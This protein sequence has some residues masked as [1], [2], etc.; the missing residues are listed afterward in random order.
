MKTIIYIFLF[1][2]FCSFSQSIH[3]SIYFIENVGQIT[4]QF[5]RQNEDVLFLF[6]DSKGMNTHLRGNGF[7][8]EFYTK[9][10]NSLKI[11]RVDI[12]FLNCNKNIEIR[13]EKQ[14]Q[15]FT[16]YYKVGA[17]NQ[18]FSRVKS[19]EVIKYINVYDFIDFEFKL[20]QNDSQIKYDIV[21]HPGADINDIKLAYK[22]YN[23]F[24]LSD[25]NRIQMELDFR[26]ITEEIP[27]SYYKENKTKEYIHFV[28]LETDKHQTT[29]GFGFNGK[30]ELKNT[31]IIDPV[32]NYV[33]GKY[34]GDSLSTQTNGV[35]TD[36]FG[37]VYIC[38]STQSYTNIATSGA[39]QTTLSDSISDAYVSKYH[40]SGAL[41]WSTYF[42]GDSSDVANDVYVDTSFNILLTGATKSYVGI[43]DS[44]SHQDS[45]GG[46]TDAFLARF[47]E[48][49]ALIWATYFGGDSIDIGKKLSVDF[50]ENIYLCGNTN[51]T[52][53]IASDSAF[54]DS[55]NGGID[56]F[57]AKFNSSG[58]LIWSSYIGGGNKDL[59]TGISYGDTAIFISGQTYS[60]D[61][62]TQSYTLMD[63]LYGESDGFIAKIDN[64]GNLIW[65]TYF[66]GENDDNIK[67]VKAI[68]NNIYF[69]GST[70]SSANIATI[71]GA[72]TIKND[73]TDAFIGK[74]DNNDSLVWCTYFGGDSLDLGVDLFFELDSSII[75]VGTTKS[76]FITGL[77]SNSYQDNNNGGFDTYLSKF[78][79][80]GTHVWS[81][82]FGG[83]KDDIAS[84]VAV[85]GNTAIYIVGTTFSD[86]NL[87]DTSQVSVNNSFNSLEEGFITKFNQNRSTPS[88]SINTGS[89]GSGGTG[90]GIPGG[91][92]GTSSYNYHC[93]GEEII[94]STMGGEL[95]TDAIWVWYIG[96]C[97]NSI[98]I[99]T[100]D[101]ISVYPFTT[102]TYYVRAESVTNSTSCSYITVQ[103]AP[104][105]VVSITSNETACIGD[106][107][108]LEA[109]G[110]GS[111]NWT[112]PN[113]LIVNQFDSTL[114]DIS[115][116]LN[117][118]FY[119]EVI[120][121][122]GCSYN[123]SMNL[124]IN[125]SMNYL[126]T[127]TDISCFGVNDGII[128]ISN[129][130]TLN[131]SIEWTDFNNSTISNGTSLLSNLTPGQYQV[132][133]IDTNN[134]I[135]IDSFLV[136]EPSSVL[137]D[138]ILIPSSCNDST[139][140]I[141]FSIDSLISNYTISVDS[142]TLTSD[143]ALYLSTGVHQVEI[144]LQ[145]G[146]IENHSIE[147]GFKNTLALTID[148]IANSFCSNIPSGY[149]SFSGNGGLQP[150]TYEWQ[151][152]AV[153]DSVATQ[154]DSGLYIVT[155]IDSANCSISDTISIGIESTIIVFETIK[156]SL[157]SDS[158][159]SISL[160]P[161]E[162]NAAYNI[163]FSNGVSNQWTIQQLSPGSYSAIIVDSIGCEFQFS[164]EVGVINDLEI[165]ISPNDTIV[166]PNAV[167]QMVTIT[168]SAYQLTY[169]WLPTPDFDCSTCPNPIL[170]TPVSSNYQLMAFDSIGCVDTANL[171]VFI[172]DNSKCIDVF[173][174]S[175]FSP[176]DDKNN[177]SWNVIGG[178]IEEIETQVYNS[179][180]E[181]IFESFDQTKGWN[182]LYNGQLVSPEQYVYSIKIKFSN[183]ENRLF[184]GFVTVVL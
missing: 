105:T 31:L 129:A 180:G 35:I 172:R 151:G 148:S 183:G 127:T 47:D 27:L 7:S 75:A 40:K 119:I 84:S 154:L 106:D 152:L 155:V 82:F 174:P 147:I 22:G 49:G 163:T 11:N 76:S 44:L 145:D 36:R 63:S 25:K 91:G 12:D 140:A 73:S 102:T 146:C 20:I 71:L 165:I 107:Y 139:G 62:P 161:E 46:N 118:W 130:D 29:I 131:T 9:K 13:A 115:D 78:T 135:Y 121:T 53:N 162:S 111:I 158:T 166:D 125:Q 83:N 92:N 33:W 124:T 37:Y 175:M 167:I 120:D 137:L 89:N 80:E 159:G 114:Y 21:L 108:L 39:Y 133:I 164:Y 141:L 48:N 61:F 103:V 144:T 8:Y 4:D 74:I 117:G 112:G 157:C 136:T 51:S 93:P 132:E 87:I 34:I 99:G 184:S 52:T 98:A 104:L 32:P 109:T 95:G 58:N 143:S 17:E 182:G 122:F 77:D 10:N 171:S 42:G 19:F 116:S 153:I 134:C 57:I 50:Y 5:N 126:I 113:N 14:H 96:G 81:S 168:N 60:N 86:T 59:A 2:S 94:L 123:D 64:D 70:N 43:S 3:K 41:M 26:N 138:T 110:N 169:Q 67:N 85:Y 177:D 101:S 72:F 142:M 55:L 38:G 160:I 88:I 15:S 170:I 178:C 30:T 24:K 149:A 179:W 1:V 18:N 79:P 65:S 128:N 56:G 176:N 68:N 66:G 54:Q 23:K 90:G 97:G 150:Y 69:I 6:S 173:I 100:G 45:I 28:Q 16:N 156:P 181:L